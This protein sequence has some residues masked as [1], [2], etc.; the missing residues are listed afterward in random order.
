MIPFEAIAP[1]LSSPKV[2]GKDELA[3]APY[4]VDFAGEHIVAGE[5]DEIYVRTIFRTQVPRLYD[6][7]VRR[8]IC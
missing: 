8:G 7:S 3:N 4:I 1:Y 6:L 5:G 2:V